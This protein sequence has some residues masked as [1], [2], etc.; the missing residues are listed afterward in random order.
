[1]SLQ[2]FLFDKIFI[3]IA[4]YLVQTTAN[5]IDTNHFFTR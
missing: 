1:M 5:L 2:S 3:M 4:I